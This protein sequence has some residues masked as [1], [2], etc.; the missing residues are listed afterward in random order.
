MERDG[1]GVSKVE[2]DVAEGIQ[3]PPHFQPS[4]SIP[5]RGAAAQ[6]LI[7]TPDLPCSESIPEPTFP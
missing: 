6:W 7:P 1:N 4:T 5:R 2:S 3:R